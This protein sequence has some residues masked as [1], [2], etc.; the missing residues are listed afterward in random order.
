MKEDYGM[1]R[2]ST[3]SMRLKANDRSEM[4]SQ[5]LFGEK[6]EVISAF[7]KNWV[8]VR[9]LLDGYEGWVDRRLISYMDKKKL[10]KYS[11]SHAL[12]VEYA[13]GIASDTERH[14]VCYG[15][16]LPLFDGISFKTPFGKFLYNGQFIHPEKV[17]DKRELLTRIAMKYLNTPYLWGGRSPFGIDCSGFTQVL[18]KLVGI[19]LPRDASQQ[20]NH[21]NAVAFVENLK[22]GDLVFFENKEGLIHHVGIYLEANKI[23]HAS[24]TVH[25]DKLDHFGIYS[26][27]DSKYTHRLRIGKNLLD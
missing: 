8:K 25:V 13:Q 17:E 26:E 3:A 10:D 9:C 14:A 24:G 11:V 21:G 16:E 22:P 20:I 7:R 1:C 5:I 15:A 2:V 19:N 6:V 12:A 18:Y 4:V 27:A 23:I